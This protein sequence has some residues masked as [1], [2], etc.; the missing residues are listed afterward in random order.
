MLCLF[1]CQSLCL[2]VVIIVLSGCMYF[3]YFCLYVFLLFS[4]I[5]NQSMLFN[6]SLSK[7]ASAVECLSVHLFACP[8][9]YLPVC[10]PVRLFACPSVCLPIC[11]PV[12]MFAC[13]SVYLSVGLPAC[14]PVCLSVCPSACLS[15]C[16]SVCHFLKS[17]FCD[18]FIISEIY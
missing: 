4:F 5:Q 13:P 8:S 10:L 18:I 17:I 14:L 12:H 1:V 7:S 3:L 2:P 15:A 9:V 6:I 11:L 16:L